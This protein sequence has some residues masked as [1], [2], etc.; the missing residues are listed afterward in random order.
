MR[1]SALLRVA[2]V[3]I[4]ALFALPNAAYA[5]TA[6]WL[7]SDATMVAGPSPAYKTVGNGAKG[8]LVVVDRCS[9]GYCKID[10]EGIAGWVALSE[11]SFGL[12][13]RGP[14][15]G[16]HFNAKSGGGTACLYT[17]TGYS[18]DS[19]CRDS[20]FVVTDFARTGLDD[21]FASI[22]VSGDASV[23][24]CRD[25]NFTSYCETIT[26]DTPKLHRFLVNNVS[27]IHI[28]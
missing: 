3:V 28:Y 17:G 26:T 18:G 13:A 2:L 14:W 21:Q 1:S 24:V 10:F 9:R 22:T 12:E 11:L 19:L 8:A 5:N 6:A 7:L 15:T 4:A 16:A 23:L 20:G 25:M 27:S